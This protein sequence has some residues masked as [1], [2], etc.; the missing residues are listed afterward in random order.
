MEE[1]VFVHLVS[2]SR[3]NESVSRMT[4]LTS[5]FRGLGPPEFRLMRRMDEAGG[6]HC[7]LINEYLT[8][9]ILIISSKYPNEFINREYKTVIHS[10]EASRDA[11]TFLDKFTTRVEFTVGGLADGQKLIFLLTRL[12]LDK[13]CLDDHKSVMESEEG[14]F[15]FLF[16]I[17][18]CFMLNSS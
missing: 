2:L 14:L 13:F 5:N 11:N 8:E 9:T 4:A 10:V 16:A 7:L 15:L 6:I 18:G 17:F 3:I 1:H 12:F